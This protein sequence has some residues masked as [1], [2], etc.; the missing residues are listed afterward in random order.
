MTPGQR[1]VALSRNSL[2]GVWVQSH[3]F[4]VDGP[5]AGNCGIGCRWRP[6]ELRAELKAVVGC[7]DWQVPWPM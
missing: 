1:E 4:R 5:Y 3:L 7:A 6:R 2:K